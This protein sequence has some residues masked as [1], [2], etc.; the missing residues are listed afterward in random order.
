MTAAGVRGLLGPKTLGTWNLHG[1]SR[2]GALDFFVMFSSW[3]SVLGV[4]DLGHYNAANQFIDA[5]A[6]YRRSLHLPAISVNWGTWD[7]IRNVSAELRSEIERFGLQFMPSAA[8][9]TAM[10]RAASAGTTQ[11]II[12]DVD[13]QK[14]KP[15]YETRRS[16]PIL[17]HV[18]NLAEPSG[19][20]IASVADALA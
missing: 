14:L 3:A 7:V 13:W 10:Y 16:R 20:Y 2:D 9:F 6:H 17:K 18:Y 8:A 15:L 12:A 5:V 4:Q 1:A 19:V 11:L